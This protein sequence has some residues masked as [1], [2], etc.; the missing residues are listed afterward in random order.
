MFIPYG[1]D[2]EKRHPPFATIFI[3]AV[4]VLVSMYEFRLFKD[5]PYAGTLFI[6]FVEHW[7]LIPQELAHGKVIG[8]FTSMFLHADLMHLLGNMFTLWLFA[9][10]IE[11]ALGTVPFLV[12]YIFWGMVA[13]AT[14]AAFAW[15]SP[16]PCVGASGAIFGVVGAYF[17]TF[18]ITAQVKCLWNGGILTGWRWTKIQMPA[19]AYMF[20]WMIIPQ[21][22]GILRIGEPEG[23][24]ASGAG[25]AWY[26]H[27]GGFAA[28]ALSM[29]IF[30]GDAMRKVRMNRD[31]KWEIHA[32][33]VETAAESE[34]A[35]EPE[36]DAVNALLPEVPPYDG[37]VCQYCQRPLEDAHK[38]D[39]TLY[40]CANPDCK[41]LTYVNDEPMAAPG[42]S[43]R[44]GRPPAI[45]RRRETET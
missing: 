4:N 11:M 37:P 36:L 45:F 9:W 20:F 25:I 2:L 30:G 18:G 40:R 7:G 42:K 22:A 1:D 43:G 26:A 14:H 28:G 44:W 33:A 17:V 38:M 32:N 31:G 8:L 16:I 5:E 21:V 12:L 39:E 23:A 13:A 19:G 15:H 10:T 6:R 41:R 35:G 27:A 29:V 34:V 24:A 3:I